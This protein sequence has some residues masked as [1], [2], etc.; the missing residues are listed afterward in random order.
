MAYNFD[1]DKI[2]IGEYRSLF[3]KEQSADEG[4]EILAK[5]AGLTLEGIHAL[6]FKQYKRLTAE[7][8]KA[9]AKVDPNLESESTT[10]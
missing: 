7:F 6:T 9:A 10:P 3:D 8:F 2:T 5:A 4:D 1:F